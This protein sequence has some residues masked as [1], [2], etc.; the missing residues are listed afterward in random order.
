MVESVMFFALGFLAAILLVLT[1]I[2][3]VH[4][5]AERLAARRLSAQVPWSFREVRAEKDA[6]RARFAVAAY[7]YERTIE[8]LRAR[9][10]TELADIGRKSNEVN[11]LKR[12]L[13]ETIATI[14]VLE[15]HN[16]NLADHAAADAPATVAAPPIAPRSLADSLADLARLNP[17]LDDPPF[18]PAPEAQ[19]RWDGNVHLLDEARDRRTAPVGANRRGPSSAAAGDASQGA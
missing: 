12:D 18:K 2:P 1:I 17:A 4:A 15:A 13:A 3:L 9:L 8:Q 11:R 14:G 5:R 19:T 10:A 16:R 7:R 6:L